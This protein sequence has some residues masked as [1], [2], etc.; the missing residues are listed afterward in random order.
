MSKIQTSSSKEANQIEV[1]PDVIDNS[2]DWEQTVWDTA[3]SSCT[4]M[5]EAAFEDEGIADVATSR[6]SAAY[7][8]KYKIYGSKKAIR[9]RRRPRSEG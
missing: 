6:I 9:M 4:T 7:E 2:T 1:D 5:S 3:S 8:A